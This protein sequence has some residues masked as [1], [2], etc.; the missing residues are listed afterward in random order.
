MLIVKKTHCGL[1]VGLATFAGLGLGVT[2]VLAQSV[3]LR[4]QQIASATNTAT[5]K[6]LETTVDRQ[7]G[8]DSHGNRSRD[9]VTTIKQTDSRNTRW[10][11]IKITVWN[12]DRGEQN[13]VI[14]WLFFARDTRSKSTRVY[15]QGTKSVALAAG[16]QTSLAVASQP[17]VEN[18]SR[19]SSLR[20]ARRSTSGETPGGY[21][22]LAKANARLL[23][24]EGSDAD[25]KRPYQDE[26][27][28]TLHTVAP[29]TK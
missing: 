11:N 13:Y 6:S 24:V 26:L 12:M 21:V 17:I 2:G 3:N 19:T 5:S 4:V 15:D 1:A 23:A 8:Y 25:L 10:E 9:I 7:P 20:G 29:K 16:E 28:K 22:V 18:V 14:E 27:R